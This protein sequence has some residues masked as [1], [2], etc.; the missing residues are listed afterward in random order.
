MKC[1]RTQ[2]FHQVIHCMLRQNRSSEKHIQSILGFINCVP[3]IYSMGHPNISASNLMK[4]PLLYKGLK[5][6]KKYNTEMD[7]LFSNKC[8]PSVRKLKH[9]QTV[10]IL[11]SSG[12]TLFAFIKATFGLQNSFELST[13]NHVTFPTRKRPSLTEGTI[14]K[15]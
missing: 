14:Q 1:H 3:S 10:K 8:M 15:R 12:S 4:N 5:Y 7:S 9:Q 2:H 11:I 6:N 13:W